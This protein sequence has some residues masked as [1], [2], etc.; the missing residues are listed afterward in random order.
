MSEFEERVKRGARSYWQ[1]IEPDPS[2]TERLVHAV[3]MDAKHQ[4]QQKSW[5]RIAVA[6]LVASIL[7]AVSLPGV[8]AA[9]TDVI[10]KVFH[11]GS[12][13]YVVNSGPDPVPVVEEPVVNDLDPKPDSDN[14]WFYTRRGPLSVEALAA[15]EE[16]AKAGPVTGDHF[17]LPAWLPEDA[18]KRL[19]LPLESAAYNDPRYAL[20]VIS[21]GKP[22]MVAAR[23]PMVGYRE[24]IGTTRLDAKK[25]TLGGVEGLEVRQGS[26]VTYYFNCDNVE[27][28]V[29]GPAAEAETVMKIAESLPAR[30]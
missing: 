21:N 29:F 17:R 8:R 1:G 4:A 13:E 19:Q 12:A 24:F 3:A 23:S 7:F 2:F 11:I 15:V 16:M 25:V 28:Q 22:I 6:G 9:A 20:A 5:T 18:P 10:R 30:P 14:R 27:Y 26:K